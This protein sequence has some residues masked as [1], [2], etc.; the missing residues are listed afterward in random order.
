MHDD[1]VEKAL[2]T[3]NQG[4]GD[5]QL[6]LHSHPRLIRVSDNEYTKALS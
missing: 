6:S 1:S 4:L 5:Y 3:A 2:R